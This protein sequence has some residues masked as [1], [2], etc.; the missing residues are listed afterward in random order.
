LQFELSSQRSLSE[1]QETY[2]QDLQEEAERLKAARA[3]AAAAAAAPAAQVSN[4]GDVSGRN[5]PKTAG[6]SASASEGRATRS[7]YSVRDPAG[8][9]ARESRAAARKRMQLQTKESLFDEALT[10]EDMRYLHV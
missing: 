10:E 9:H 7:S 6:A 8:P 3:A 2:I 4:E 5:S 1:I